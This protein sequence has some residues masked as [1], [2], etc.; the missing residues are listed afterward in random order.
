MIFAFT[1][2]L[3][4]QQ[5]PLAEPALT[6]RARA[7]IEQI[8]L[9]LSSTHRFSAPGLILMSTGFSGAALFAAT[10]VALLF[11]G[12]GNAWIFCG[13]FSVG[14]LISGA[15]GVIIAVIDQTRSDRRVIALKA[16]RELLL[17][18]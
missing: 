16:E 3:L 13:G 8:E 4:L 9:E 7:R 1:T 5:A 15:I 6:P 18:P 11:R 2:A 14:G 17:T 10:S 12:T